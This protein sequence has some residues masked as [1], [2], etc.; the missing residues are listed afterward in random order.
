MGTWYTSQP[1]GISNWSSWKTSNTKKPG[2]YQ[3]RTECRIG[4]GS[5]NNVCVHIKM[6]A[7]CI[8]YNAS[9]AT[10]GLKAQVSIGGTSN[11]KSSDQ[12][13]SFALGVFIQ[14]PPY[15][16]EHPM[17]WRAKVFSSV[18]CNEDKFAISYP[19]QLRMSIILV[20]SMLHSIYNGI[21]GHI[22]I[23]CF[24]SRPSGLQKTRAPNL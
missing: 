6:E 22:D 12:Y 10:V 14:Y 1:S 18:R 13:S 4:R 2:T 20:D 8:D 3:F 24:H 11:Y 7:Q 21:A 19:V 9:P 15:G 23:L 16:A 17:H 5:T